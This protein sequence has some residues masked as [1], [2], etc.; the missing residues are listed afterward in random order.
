M[1]TKPQQEKIQKEKERAY[2]MHLTGMNTRDIGF[3][4]GK[5]H[6]WVANAVR[7]LSTDPLVDKT[8]QE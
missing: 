1:R 8:L 6:T 3:A 5:S 2:K 4:M 7:E